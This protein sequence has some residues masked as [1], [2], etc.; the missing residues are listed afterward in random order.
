MQ[1]PAEFYPVCLA[2]ILDL[3]ETR[4]GVGGPRG[5]EVLDPSALSLQPEPAGALPNR[6]DSL[7]GYWSLKSRHSLQ[8]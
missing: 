5:T 2:P 8:H 4:Q 1:R 3:C 6:R 7:G